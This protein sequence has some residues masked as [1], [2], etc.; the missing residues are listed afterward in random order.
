MS[1]VLRFPI[2]RRKDA[3]V[4]WPATP[5]EDIYWL[6][7]A[8]RLRDESGKPVELPCDVEPPTSK[9]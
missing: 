5:P 1:N 7:D 8:L 4:A 9:G 3:F 2:E 6:A